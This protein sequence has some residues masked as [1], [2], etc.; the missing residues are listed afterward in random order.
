DDSAGRRP[1]GEAP[2]GRA[3][4]AEPFEIAGA[5]SPQPESP[6][7]GRL[8]WP[9]RSLGIGPGAREILLLGRQE[10]WTVEGEK[11]VTRPD[12]FPGL[13]D[14]ERFDVG[15]VLEGDVGE[16]ALVDVDPPESA[17]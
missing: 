12:G 9:R 7:S 13:G 1:Q 5:E 8:Q 3:A 4:G 11:P 14:Q 6:G 2:I 10:V 15:L 16:L 17:E